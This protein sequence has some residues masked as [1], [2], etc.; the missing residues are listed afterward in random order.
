MNII[1][2]LLGVM[3][4]EQK[5]KA[6]SDMLSN[7]NFRIGKIEN[8]RYVIMQ[9]YEA[10]AEFWLKRNG[11]LT[12]SY[13]TAYDRLELTEKIMLNLLINKFVEGGRSDEI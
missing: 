12:I 11:G 6:L 13:C 10:F 1:N 3:S 2:A 5:N 8:D 9:Q 4:E 7:N